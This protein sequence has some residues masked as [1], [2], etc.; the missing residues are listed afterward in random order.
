MTLPLCSAIDS[1]LFLD[2]DGGIRTCCAGKFNLGNINEESLPM[3]FAKKE[4]IEAKQIMD[5][6]SLPEYCD[7]CKYQES[8]A[9]DS[10]QWRYYKEH[11]PANG[12]K[13]LRHIDVRWSNVCN[14]SCR[15]CDPRA[16][17]Q[18]QKLL[19]IPLENVNR[20]Y[21]ESIFTY[22]EENLDT[23]EGIFLLGGE[24]LMQ[25]QNER[26][27]EMVNADTRIDIVTNMSTVLENNKIYNLLK[28]KK[29]VNW[30][31]SFENIGDRFEYVRHGASWDRLLQNICTLE[32]D[33]GHDRLKIHGVYSIWSATCVTEFLEFVHKNKIPMTWTMAYSSAGI[34]VFDHLP[35]VRELA[36]REIE[37]IGGST[38][39]L[40]LSIFQQIKTS[41]ETAPEVEN[42]AANFL[43]WT[44]NNEQL[45][46]PA[47]TFAELWPELF[48]ALNIQ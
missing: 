27:F 4:Y 5:S 46:P 16:S 24:P 36:L 7:N 13:K 47:H 29:N 37:R 18:W 31:I 9:K 1:S 38:V 6:G 25:K 3:I 15:Y 20:G 32:D 21:H 22:I 43:E 26:L 28:G 30:S 33:F 2:T 45:M 40:D 23:L 14:L 35:A 34:S 17:S 10:S 41:L 8:V 12:V 11:I 48:Q 39:Y 19:N 44:H 42:A